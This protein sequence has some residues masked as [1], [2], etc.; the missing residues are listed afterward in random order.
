MMQLIDMRMACHRRIVPLSDNYKL[1]LDSICFFVARFVCV[2]VSNVLNFARVLL[3]E[4][5]GCSDGSDQ[6]NLKG[7]AHGEQHGGT[8]RDEEGGQGPGPG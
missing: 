2:C 5:V 4:F 6:T 1:N 8:Q 3:E 7:K